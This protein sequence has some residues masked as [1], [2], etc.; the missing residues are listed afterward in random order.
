MGAQGRRRRALPRVVRVAHASQ[1][2]PGRGAHRFPRGPKELDVS[3]VLSAVRV[4]TLIMPRPSQPGPAY[5]IAERIRGATVVE[6]PPFDG[7]YTWVDDDAH[8]ATMEATRDFI[9]RLTER[10]E[11][12]RVLAT[13]LFTDIVGSTELASR[14]GDS[15][16]RALLERHHATVRREL[17]RFQ[18]RELDTAGDG[19]FA[20]FDGPARAVHAA[21]AIIDALQILDLEIRAGVHTGECE[22]SDGKI[23]GVAV[24]IGARIASLAKPGEVLVSSTVQDLVAGSGLR[25]EDRGEHTL[26]GVRE[27][28]RVFAYAKPE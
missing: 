27:P 2:Q 16:W 28:W 10:G 17:S 4:P 12:E 20:T 23:V 1:P 9:S 22:V 18:G 24:S 26:K 3:D 21:A 8:Q 11:A 13:V 6:L 19:F 5:Y 14:L 25:F 7:H 15:G